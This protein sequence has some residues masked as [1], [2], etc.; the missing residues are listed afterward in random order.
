MLVAPD[1]VQLSVLLEPELMPVGLA[2][3]ALMVGSMPLLEEEPDVPPQL[4]SPRLIRRIATG[5]QMCETMALK[6]M[7]LGFSV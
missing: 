2:A 7:E 3:N 5:S 1:V 4:I 6:I